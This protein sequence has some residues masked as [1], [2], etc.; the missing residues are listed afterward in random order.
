MGAALLVGAAFALLAGAALAL[1]V[2]GCGASGGAASTAAGGAS[3]ESS[4]ATAPFTHQEQLVQQGARLYV[5]DGC[6]ACHAIDTR[7]GALGPSF[8]VLAGNEVTLRDGRRALVDERFLHTALTAP[9]RTEVRGYAP[10][11]MLA[12]VR[13]LRLAHDPAAVAALAAFIEQIG[14]ETP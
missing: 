14:P 11:P 7:R 3:G 9:A 8:A 6:S 2:A 1:A 10:A 13:R 12:A 4:Y 5:A